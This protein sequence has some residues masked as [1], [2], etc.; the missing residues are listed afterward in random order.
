MHRTMRTTLA[1]ALLAGAAMGGMVAGQAVAQPAPPPSAE[2]QRGGPPPGAGRGHDQD[3]RDGQR[4]EG[5]HG[6]RGEHG[7]GE[8]GRGEQGRGEHGRMGMMGGPM[9]GAFAMFPRVEDK[10]L[11]VPEVQKIAEG[12]LLFMGQRTW[13][14]VEVR[15]AG[16][17]IEFG[18]AAAEGTPAF[19]KFKVDR[20]TGRPERIG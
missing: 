5:R 1:A 8:H 18:I 15:E 6:G 7:R 13:R 9:G 19:A 14:V 2:A 10:A 20:K 11:T 16:S 17:A 4:H 12:F 3:R